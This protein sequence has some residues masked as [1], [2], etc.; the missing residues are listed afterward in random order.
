M[1]RVLGKNSVYIAARPRIPPLMDME[2]SCDRAHSPR[3]AHCVRTYSTRDGSEDDDDVALPSDRLTS[4]AR[5][6]PVCVPHS[7]VGV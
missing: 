7:H 5:H 1:E 2:F 3:I 6:A 4:L